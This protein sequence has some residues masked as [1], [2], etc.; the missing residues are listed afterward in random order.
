MG[1]RDERP[2]ATKHEVVYRLRNIPRLLFIRSSCCSQGNLY[3]RPVKSI[4]CCE[5]VFATRWRE[6]GITVKGLS[7]RAL[8]LNRG[9]PETSGVSLVKI[10][11]EIGIGVPAHVT[12]LARA[13]TVAPTL[14]HF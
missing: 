14:N 11:S 13:V 5:A 1:G 9:P 6:G 12:K 7:F 8:L 4:V 10:G 2:L 3:Q